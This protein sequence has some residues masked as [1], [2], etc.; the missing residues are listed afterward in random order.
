MCLCA[1][2]LALLEE[3]EVGLEPI[4]KSDVPEGIHDLFVL[5]I[6]QMSKL[7]AEEAKHHQAPRPEAPLQLV[8]L[9]VAPDSCASE[10]CHILKEKHL[11]L[12]GAQAHRLPASQWVHREGILR[13]LGLQP[14]AERRTCLGNERGALG[15]QTIRLNS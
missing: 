2:H 10:L 14:P 13:A 15:S 6:L 4:A 5:G 11:A 3:H 1:I 7:V 12:Q 8:H 9:G